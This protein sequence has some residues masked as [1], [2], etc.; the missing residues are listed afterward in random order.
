[1]KE[2]FLQRFARGCVVSGVA[3][4]IMKE[5]RTI[6][7]AVVVV[8]GCKDAPIAGKFAVRLDDFLNGNAEDVARA[9]V[10]VEIEVPAENVCQAHG[11][12]GLFSRAGYRSEKRVFHS[13]ADAHSLGAR[14]N[15]RHF[16]MKPAV[17]RR[18]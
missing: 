15:L 4:G 2:R 18:N 11:K 9:R 13:A 7:L 12:L 10:G 16:G 8:L 14:W 3:G 6:D 17:A 5:N 1:M